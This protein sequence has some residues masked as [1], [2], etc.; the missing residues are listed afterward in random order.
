[1]G[2]NPYRGR[3]EPMHAEDYRIT[4]KMMT[5]TDTDQFSDRLINELSGGEE[6]TVL[7]AR[8]L[9]QTPQFLLLDEPTSHL[10]IYHQMKILGSIR[11]QSHN[12][13]IVVVMHDLNMAARFCDRLVLL[14]Q[15]RVIAE[16]T[17]V[18][19]LTPSHVKSVFHTDSVVRHDPDLN[20]I[21]LTFSNNGFLNQGLNHQ[22]I[23]EM[24]HV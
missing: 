9:T 8:A 16:G 11:N 18:E 13:G 4:E 20:A 24:T 19:V 2:R 3:F 21:Q 1:M 14:F 23:K 5:L 7:L 17:P 6:Q 10:D 22:K 15:G 12:M